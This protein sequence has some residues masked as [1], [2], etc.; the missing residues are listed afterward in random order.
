M[1]KQTNT[2]TIKKMVNV[3]KAWLDRYIKKLTQIFKTNDIKYIQS[4][5]REIRK[6]C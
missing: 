5:T 6:L 3:D 1:V 2:N 4:M